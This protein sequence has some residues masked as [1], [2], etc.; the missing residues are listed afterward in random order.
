MDSLWIRG[1][2]PESALAES[3]E[4]SIQWREDFAMTYLQRD[5][6]AIGY[7]IRIPAMTL[8]R[9]WQML[10]HTHGQLANLSQLAAN[11]ELSRQSIRRYLDILRETFM[12][13]SLQPYHVNLKKR[14]VKAPKVYL[15]DSGI[16]HTLLG[17]QTF[18]DLL[19]HPMLGMSWEGFC[20]EQIL[21][22]MPR[23]WEAFF[24]RTQ[25]KAEVDL[26]LQRRF[27]E[28]PILVEFKHSQSPK[29]TRGFWSAREDIE[30]Q[31]CYVIYPG[32]ITYPLAESVEVL[33]LTEIAKLWEQQPRD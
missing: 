31:A 8:R 24:Y 9:F 20:L 21:A 2:F 29:L 7:D 14:L 23:S 4:A 19:G 32:S 15:R 18:E 12:I 1:G 10:A 6:S 25:A 26:V 13:R 30:P 27:G 22:T 28:A 17:I 5:L 3:E 11:L 33:P 16:L